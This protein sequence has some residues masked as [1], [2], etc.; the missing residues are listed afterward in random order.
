MSLS[1]FEI[2]LILPKDHFLIGGAK[3]KKEKT[4]TYESTNE[5]NSSY[6]ISLYINKILPSRY[7][8]TRLLI[9]VLPTVCVCVCVCVCVYSLVFVFWGPKTWNILQHLYVDQNAAPYN[10]IFQILG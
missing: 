6:T 8:V 10:A 4:T 2:F 7:E 9:C 1:L 5:Q 3:P